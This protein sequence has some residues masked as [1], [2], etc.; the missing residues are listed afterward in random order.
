MIA[1]GC[2]KII[3]NGKITIMAA[4]VP[5]QFPDPFDRVQVRTIGWQKIQLKNV[6][7][8]MQPW[9]ELPGM[10]PTS[11]IH[12]DQ[13]GAALSAVTDELSQEQLEGRGVKR[14]GPPRD[15]ASVLKTHCAQKGHALARG[16]VQEHRVC[17]FRRY[18]HGAS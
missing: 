17:I 18:P 11:V 16:G 6:S 5:S 3:E 14:F 9:L 2:N 4:L 12:D 1:D 15:K 10:M 7:V 8:F 13:H